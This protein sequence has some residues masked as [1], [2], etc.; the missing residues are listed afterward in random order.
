MK[1]TDGFFVRLVTNY[2]MHLYSHMQT[3]I[4]K[5][6]LKI[7]PFFKITGAIMRKESRMI[8][9]FVSFPLLPRNLSTH[10]HPLSLSQKSAM[11][12]LAMQRLSVF[13]RDRGK[14]NVC[15]K[16]LPFYLDTKSTLKH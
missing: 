11:P 1:K 6:T 4:I 10:F 14:S 16:S 2:L 7:P 5:F 9:N 3:R 15:Y 12:Q 8:N 13:E